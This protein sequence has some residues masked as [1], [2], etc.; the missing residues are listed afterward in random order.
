[1]GISCRRRVAGSSRSRTI[2]EPSK[3]VVNFKGILQC[4]LWL[5]GGGG[6]VGEPEGA[7]ILISRCGGTESS[8]GK[9]LRRSARR[10]KVSHLR[11]RT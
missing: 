2:Y 11:R 9:F 4:C 8:K 7:R 5:C 10:E 3:N 6:V 1:M